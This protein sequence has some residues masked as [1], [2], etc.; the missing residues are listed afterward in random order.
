MIC[1]IY[2]SPK[3]SEMYLYVCNRDDFT[4]I[5]EPLLKSFGNPEF[6]MMLNLTNRKSLARED[7]NTVREKLINDGF[8]LQMP[9]L[10]TADQNYLSKSD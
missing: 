7:I 9:P 2:R 8:F 1:Y 4:L 5:P 6:S 10:E 3:K